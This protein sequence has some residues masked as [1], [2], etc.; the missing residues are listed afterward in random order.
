M[1]SHDHQL[2]NQ[3]T[4]ILEPLKQPVQAAVTVPGS[5]SYTIRALL[6]AALTPKANGQPV[7]VLNPLS[8]DDGQ[9]I[10]HCLNTL[11][12][13]TSIKEE[14]HVHWIEVQNG[15]NE[16]QPGDYEL[17]A[18]LSAATLRFLLA[19]SAVIPGRQTLFGKA[20]LNNRPVR[21]LVESLR[22]IG[23][24]IEYLEREGYPPVRVNSSRIETTRLQVSGA[25]SSQY[26]SALMMIAPQIQA[27]NHGQEITI[28]LLDDPVSK[29]YLE[30][31]RS[32][33]RDFGV[34]VDNHD[35][36][37]LTT[38]ANQTYQTQSYAVEPDASSMAYFLAIAALTGSSITIRHIGEKSVQADMQFARILERLGHRVEWH[39]D[40]LTLH[41]QPLAQTEPLLIDMEDCPDQ[42]Q[43]MAVLAAFMPC[44][45]RIVGL[46]SLRVKETDRL[47]ATANEL[48][49][50][51]I[52]IEE[53]VDALVIHGGSPKAAKIATYGDHRMA[54]AFAVAG[55][56]LSG[57]EIE[58]PAV[59]NKTYPNFWHDL[60]ELGIGVQPVD[61]QN[62]VPSKIVLIGFM[63]AGKS[64]VAKQLAESLSL[65]LVEMDSEILKRSGRANITEIFEQDGETHFRALEANVAKD[66][67]SAQNV[68]IS[69]GGG[70]VM[71]EV[72][73]QALSQSASVIFLDASLETIQAR[74]VD[75]DDRPLMRD[76]TQFEPLFNLRQPLYRRFAHR[77]VH[78]DRQTP[79]Q[80]VAII[81][82][83]FG[84]MEMNPVCPV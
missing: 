61:P 63:G 15:V 33:L 1:N 46:Q 44:V 22:A 50:M 73:M 57:L 36:R 43:T 52:Q 67:V 72:N 24:D 77:T 18:N 3:D 17:D 37:Q 11:G 20:G 76:K 58:D 16:I 75:A 71:N 60:R 13:K 54:M 64:A 6:L 38:P 14:N 84:K 56:K 70:V 28:E 55:A 45:T 10:L 34:T 62:A 42:A 21:D 27:Q 40:E 31:T 80:V 53:E 65:T 82:Q 23:A 26:I 79:E 41:G 7:K 66:L 47:A 78:T 81:L 68:I 12:I 35:F 59:V 29:P 30:M 83:T 49:K 25:T 39:A 32:I 4:V 69:C 9:A 48:T 74:L 8:S 5:K 2:E 51:G 19:L